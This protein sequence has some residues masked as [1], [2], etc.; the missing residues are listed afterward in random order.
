MNELFC[1]INLVVGLLIGMVIG[2][3]A[4]YYEKKTG[5]K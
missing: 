5:G 4:T 1:L 3:L 2:Y